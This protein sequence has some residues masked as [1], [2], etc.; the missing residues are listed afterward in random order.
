M[1][2]LV[3]LA[4]YPRSGNTWFRV[5]LSSVLSGNRRKELNNLEVDLYAN[6]RIMFDELAGITSSELTNDEI[7]N[8]KPDVFQLLSAETT[9]LLYL[10]THDRFFLTQA[11]KPAFPPAS[12]FGCVY[13]IRN[14]LDV[15]VSN[16]RYF[17][18]SAD[19]VIASMNDP[20]HALHPSVNCLHPLL[21]EWLGDWSGHV[22][23]WLG[24]GNSIHVVRYEDMIGAPVETFSKA[25]RFL[26]VEFTEKQVAT[27]ISEASFEALKRSEEQFGFKER[28]PS[29]DAFFRHGKVGGWRTFLTD[30]QVK[31]IVDD[32]REVM[33]R[34]G[35]L[36]PGFNNKQPTII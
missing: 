29:C 24:S 21:E 3:W 9:G 20:G 7:R 23:G 25:L 13:I 22:T 19:E 18:K 5:F 33:E 12:S 1:K 35:Y 2:N 31:K 11:G 6:S 4:S 30:I 17:S 14:P 28:L 26:D 27:A 34:F 15:A 32:H 36:E 8:L 16:A 10:K